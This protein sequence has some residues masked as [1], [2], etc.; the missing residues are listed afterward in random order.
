MQ[1]EIFDVITAQ[2]SDFTIRFVKSK[3]DID[4]MLENVCDSTGCVI[5]NTGDSKFAVKG[6]DAP[7][8]ILSESLLNFLSLFSCVMRTILLPR[9]G[10]YDMTRKDDTTIV[11]NSPLSFHNR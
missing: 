3:H 1:P 4:E 2:I 11:L 5:E 8:I 10:I 6:T 7:I 9:E